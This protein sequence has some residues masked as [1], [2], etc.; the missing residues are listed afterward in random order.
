MRDARPRRNDSCRVKAS[1]SEISRALDA[2]PSAIRLFLLHGA[3]ES[4]SIALSKRL[5]RACG[6]DAERVDLDATKLKADPARLSDE[7]ASFSMFGGKRYIRIQPVSDDALPAIIALLEAGV[8]EHPVIAIAGALKPASAL[9][10]LALS[11][12]A[13][14]AHA[15]F[16]PDAGQASQIAEALGRESGL[17]LSGDIARAIASAAGNDRAVMAQ[18]IEKLALFMDA[19]PERPVEATMD[20]L[21][22]IGAATS[23]GALSRLVDAVL[24]GRPNSVADEV[25]RLSQEGMEGIPLLRAVSRRVHMLAGLRA[26]VDGGLSAG[27]AVKARGKAIFWKDEAPVTRQVSRWPSTRLATASSR[28]LATEQAIMS[29]GTAGTIL[30]DAELIAISRV[31]ARLR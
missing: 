31:A 11:S 21:E 29:A 4:S 12:P 19:G 25:A 7:A 15:S 8:A 1:L 3:D 30:C 22:S 23:D 26:E 10:K 28:L 16:I 18:E 9:L 24:D 5:E 2:P 13:I 14:M 20:S 6:A 27:A 17:R